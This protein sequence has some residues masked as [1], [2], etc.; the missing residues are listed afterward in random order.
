MNIRVFLYDICVQISN[1]NVFIPTISVF[2]K[3]ISVYDIL[4]FRFY[5]FMCYGGIER[6]KIEGFDVIY[7]KKCLGF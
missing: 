4:Q 1:N 3:E 7:L 2:M 6:W 5:F